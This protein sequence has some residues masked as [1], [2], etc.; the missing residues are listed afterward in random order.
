MDHVRA[1]WFA[2]A[3]VGPLL[4]QG[5]GGD[6]PRAEKPS[7]TVVI[8]TM[9]DLSPHAGRGIQMLRGVELA[10]K[11]AQEGGRL[12]CDLELQIE[13][14]RGDPDLALDHARNLADNPS[15]V[16]CLCAYT[17]AEAMAVGGELSAAG[18]LMSGPAPGAEISKQG[19]GTWFG[20]APTEEI[21]ATATVDYIRDTLGP[22]EVAVV[23][24]GSEEGAAAADR[25]ATGLGSL[26]SKRL[27]LGADDVTGALQGA[28]IPLVYV[29]AD[30][31]GAVALAAELR[32]AGIAA[33]IVSNSSGLGPARVTPPTEG[34][35]VACPCVDVGALPRG[36]TFVR[37]FAEAYEEPPGPFA[38]EM[39]DVTNLVIE[40]LEPSGG[41]GDVQ[42]LR[43]AVVERFGE[44]QAERGISRRLEWTSTGD[45][46]AEP[47]LDTWIYEWQEAAGTFVSLGPVADL[48]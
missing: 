42:D 45:L 9:G 17:T 48:R 43:D 33:T 29:G 22:N 26:V 4:L 8:G 35:Q 39:Y 10:V 18:I 21:E 25:V 40:A 15:L 23:D 19:L 14:T 27:T 31:D 28:H 30:G 36:E 47:A 5:C 34:F 7:C 44:A 11:E 24:D 13:D 37:A 1:R 32:E 38:V 20:A 12:E 6:E 16:A 46:V 41:R 2:V 3:C